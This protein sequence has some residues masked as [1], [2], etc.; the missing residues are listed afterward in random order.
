MSDA[1]DPRH[2]TGERRTEPVEGK[3]VVGL[4]EV[5]P[6]DDLGDRPRME[7][8]VAASA[9]SSAKPEAVNSPSH[10]SKGRDDPYEV[11]KVLRAWGLEGDALRWTA[12]K[13]LARAGRK[14]G[15]D[16]LEDLRKSKWY[17]DK[18]VE[19]EQEA[20]A[21]RVEIVPLE[22]FATS[23]LDGVLVRGGAPDPV[24]EP[25]LEA[26][27]RVRDLAEC[28]WGDRIRG[29]AFCGL[30]E[31]ELIK[32][33]TAVRDGFQKHYEAKR[34]AEAEKEEGKSK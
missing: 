1:S 22:A 2:A 4:F 3:R 6:E 34:E 19:R 24:V 18:L 12:V 33:Q 16:L 10:Y 29:T 14:A 23:M 27:R 15:S 7:G 17:V 8:K 5:R 28:G 11:W 25:L 31:E 21:P 20:R 9:G 13:Y 30:S 32:V 26:L